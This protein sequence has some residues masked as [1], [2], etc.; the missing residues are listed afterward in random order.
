MEK[1]GDADD[2]DTDGENAKVRFHSPAGLCIDPTDRSIV[3][4]DHGNHRIRRMTAGKTE[5]IAG[6]DAG[7]ANGIGTAAQFSAP[8]G[9]TCDAKGN[10]YV[11]ERGNNTV[12]MIDK[13]TKAVSTITGKPDSKEHKNGSFADATF[14]VMRFIALDAAGNDLFVTCKEVIAKLSLTAKQ[15]TDVAVPKA[16]KKP[17]DVDVDSDNLLIVTDEDADAKVVYRIFEKPNGANVMTKIE[18]VNEQQQ[19]VEVMPSCVAVDKAS[20]DIY[21]FDDKSRMIKKLAGSRACRMCGGSDCC[22][23]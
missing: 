8:T 21:F 9:V 19:T 16:L 13:A 4:A 12:R 1:V 22:V 17:L 5:T 14:N 7:Y 15:V 10:I 20:D 11:C 3:I 23:M 18:A 2:G 6:K